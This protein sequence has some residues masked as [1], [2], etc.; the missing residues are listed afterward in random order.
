MR[1]FI[2]PLILLAQ[3]ALPAAAADAPNIVFFLA[4]DQGWTGTSVQMDDR[5]PG[6]RSDYYRTPSLE[7]LAREGM[8]FSDAYA[9]HPNC[10]PTRMSIQTGKSPARL[11]ATDI[12][13]VVPDASGVGG[14]FYNTQYV[15][16]PMIVHLPISGLPREETTIAE[17]LK[18]AK[19]DYVTA[20]FG[21]WHMGGGSPAGHGYDVHDGATGNGEGR[22]GPPNP[23]R[24][25]EITR[26]A[27]EFLNAQAAA[28]KP[29][30]LQISAYAVHTPVSAMPETTAEYQAQP[31]GKWHNNAAYGAMTQ[32]LD[33]ALGAVLAKI[34]ELGIADN[35]YVFYTSDNGGE[36]GGGALNPEPVTSNKPLAKG[37]THVW[38]GGVRVPL[39]VRGPGI[40][41]GS[42]SHAPVI[43]WDFFPTIA[44]L[45][46]I[47]APLPD[48]IDGGSL[49]S[50]LQ[51][52][53]QGAVKRSTGAFVWY[54][55]HYRD[56]KGVRPQAAI[57]EG[58]YK[59]VRE[60]ES[61]EIHLYN[62]AADIGEERDL[63]K[64]MPDRARALDARLANYLSA[65]GAKLPAKNP[66]YDPNKTAP[67]APVRRRQPQ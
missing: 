15:N 3:L 27:V 11:G 35:T 8:R 22:E 19:P 61:G 14:M 40:K 16:K 51:G 41:A 17:F 58:G 31:P 44:E 55:P 5:V 1:R 50:I 9:P 25:P 52:G 2:A 42:V 12:I 45:A 29:F 59:L 30:Y 53:G 65:V 36:L 6:S 4:D 62:L 66:D 24:T 26:R 7:R 54:Y 48:N 60:Y 33:A 64:E 43:G 39:V 38:E 56:F 10:S 18:T 20:H 37:K 46:G 47:N 32:E 34:D 13:D 21:K 23:K 28:G 63:A 49:R 67:P 57:R